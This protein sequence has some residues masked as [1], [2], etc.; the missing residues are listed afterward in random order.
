MTRYTA[1][2]IARARVERRRIHRY[3]TSVKKIIHQTNTVSGFR[4]GGTTVNVNGRMA[5]GGYST[6][7]C[8]KRG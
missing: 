6:G 8:V 1:Y 2:V 5:S 4:S 7:R 3:P